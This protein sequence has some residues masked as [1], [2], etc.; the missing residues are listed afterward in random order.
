MLTNAKTTG[1]DCQLWEVAVVSTTGQQGID[2]IQTSESD[3]HAAS[4]DCYN[5]AARSGIIRGKTQSKPVS[6][7]WYN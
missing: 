5:V 6:I 2:R 7:F 1:L 3:S 4:S